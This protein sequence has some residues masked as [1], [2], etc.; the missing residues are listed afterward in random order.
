MHKKFITQAIAVIDIK[1]NKVFRDRIV[2]TIVLF[3]R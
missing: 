1:N 2:R 3:F